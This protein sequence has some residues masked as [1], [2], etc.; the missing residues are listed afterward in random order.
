MKHNHNR[1]AVEA[2]LVAA[3]VLVLLLFQVVGTTTVTDD[4]AALDEEGYPV[5]DKTFDDFLEPGTRFGILTGTDWAMDVEKRYP[6]A[7]IDAYN[8]FADIYE[9]LDAGKIDVAV[10]F[11]SAKPELK[12][13]HPDIAFIKEPF[14]T[15]DYGFGMP[16]TDRGKT[17]CEEFNAYM[18]QF[19]ESGGFE[20]LKQKREDPE[21]SGDVMEGYQYTG[22][23]GTLKIVTA[24]TWEPMTFYVGDTVTGEFVEL[25][26]GFCAATGYMPEIEVA[27]YSAEI[28]GLGTGEYD[29]MA[30]TAVITEERQ[31][32]IYVSALLLSDYNNLAVKVE[33][34]KRVVPKYQVFLASLRKSLYSNFITEERYRMLLS[35]LGVTLGLSLI[36]GVGGTLLGAFICFLRTRKHPLPSA[37]ASLYIRFSGG[38]LFWW[39]FWCS[40]LWCS[41]VS[42][43]PLSGCPPSPLPWILPP[44]ARKSSGAAL[45]RSRRDRQGRPRRWASPLCT[46]SGR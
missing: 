41:R 45:S 43:C 46:P 5:T 38:C 40:T 26:C 6:E 17:V 27:S 14:K 9:A 23:K 36:A 12:E 32:N 28:T 15:M 4:S 10:C 25:A 44:I 29:L 22:E 7:R 39:C 3:I 8:S 35:G 31:D 13:T 18:R 16:H 1:N 30:D 24:G 11:D 33:S 20:A 37:V 19:Q 42:R 21:R 34:R 2:L